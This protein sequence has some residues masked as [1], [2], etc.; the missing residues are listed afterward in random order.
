[1]R[2]IF[3]RHEKITYASPLRD[4][5]DSQ[6]AKTR[7][8]ALPRSPQDIEFSVKVYEGESGRMKDNYEIGEFKREHVSVMNHFN[9]DH[10]GHVLV[11]MGFTF[12]EE[13][14]L[15]VLCEQIKGHSPSRPGKKTINPGCLFPHDIERMRTLITQFE[16]DEAA[17]QRRKEAVNDLENSIISL[18]ELISY[19]TEELGAAESIFEKVLDMSNGPFVPTA[20]HSNP[21]EPIARKETAPS[22][23]PHMQHPEELAVKTNE[24]LL[25]TV[26]KKCAEY[27]N[28]RM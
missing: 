25:E 16:E 18:R 12:N 26:L 4:F 9:S 3:K 27:A 21:E 6:S 8:V 20:L 19:L 23:T 10:K 11:T 14:H 17:A 5:N 22:N 13:V 24:H 15:K 28:N 7:T 1:M 2:T